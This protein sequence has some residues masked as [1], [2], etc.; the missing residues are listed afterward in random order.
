[1]PLFA[2]RKPAESV[3]LISGT[4]TAR[5]CPRASLGSA[6]LVCDL[7]RFGGLGFIFRAMSRTPETITKLKHS[8]ELFLLLI[9]EQELTPTEA[10]A[11]AYPKANRRACSRV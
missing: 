10:Y 5:T 1:M 4:W 6:G 7:L 2:T 9:V 3:S 8:Q 11:K